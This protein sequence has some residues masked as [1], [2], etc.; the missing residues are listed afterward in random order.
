MEIIYLKKVEAF[1]KEH[2]NAAKQLR[3]WI[4]TVEKAKWTKSLDLLHDFPSANIIQPDRARFK[5]CGKKFRMI[6]E[7]DYID[8]IVEIRFIGTHTEYNRTD[9]A[10][11]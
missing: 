2:A 11:I 8:E 5:I 3:A 6:V 4:L 7:V 10:T 1:A 9:A